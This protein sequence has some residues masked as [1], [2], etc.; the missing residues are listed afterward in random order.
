ML[1]WVV[2]CICSDLLVR[3]LASVHTFY[4]ICLC[5]SFVSGIRRQQWASCLPKLPYVSFSFCLYRTH[6]PEL[7][8]RAIENGATRCMVHRLKATVPLKPWL[9]LALNNLASRL[10][11]QNHTTQRLLL[12]ISIA[13]ILTQPSS[14]RLSVALYQL[15]S[16]NPLRHYSGERGPW[17]QCYQTGHY[18]SASWWFYRTVTALCS[19]GAWSSQL[20]PSLHLD[21]WHLS[22]M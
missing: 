14:G 1:C 22:G 17:G 10:P 20:S 19:Q 21:I 15:G 11:Y 3:V 16:R 13:L 5:V 12:L 2:L 7:S 6:G 4:T 9:V 8:T 18:V